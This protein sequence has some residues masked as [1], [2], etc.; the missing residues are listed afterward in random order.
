MVRV[1]VFYGPGL[2]S[3]SLFPLNPQK[4]RETPYRSQP[5]RW[6]FVA[7]CSCCGKRSPFCA[8]SCAPFVLH[9]PRSPGSL[10]SFLF[11]EL[12]TLAK[13]SDLGSS[14][15]FFDPP[16]PDSPFA[17]SVIPPM[18]LVIRGL[19]S[20]RRRLAPPFPPEAPKTTPF[21]QSFCAEF[22]FFS[23]LRQLTFAFLT[24]HSGSP[25]R[26]LL[27]FQV[28]L[29]GRC[30]CVIPGCN[31]L[32]K[33]SSPFVPPRPFPLALPRLGKNSLFRSLPSAKALSGLPPGTSLFLPQF[34][35]AQ[36]KNSGIPSLDAFSPYGP[37]PCLIDRSCP[38]AGCPS[39]TIQRLPALKGQ[40]LSRRSPSSIKTPF[41]RFLALFLFLFSS[42]APLRFSI[43]R[44]WKNF[45]CRFFPFFS[46]GPP[47]SQPFFCRIE[48]FS[49]VTVSFPLS[50]ISPS[51]MVSVLCFLSPN[52]N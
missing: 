48:A 7:V 50:W 2:P 32:W 4:T 26:L 47:H 3:S 15:S 27:Y 11:P 13:F 41:S 37:P 52:H 21:D 36:K 20:A 31:P 24:P 6:V 12:F 16:R 40:F 19:F 14:F 43:S 51:L 38:H 44:R 17:P 1:G 33:F 46:T 23:L 10:S 9:F 25:P 5:R 42:A 28:S 39:L 22:F 49:G 30:T 45:L 29:M 18:K 34:L 35:L 8:V